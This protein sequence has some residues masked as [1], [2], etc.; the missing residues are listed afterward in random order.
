MRDHIHQVTSHPGGLILTSRAIML[1]LCARSVGAN[2]PHDIR[3]HLNLPHILHFCET[4]LHFLSP[5]G[6]IG[7][8]TWS[9]SCLIKLSPDPP[10]YAKGRTT[11]PG[12]LFSLFK[13]R[14][15]QLSFRMVQGSH[16]KGWVIFTNGKEAEKTNTGRM[17]DP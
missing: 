10:A 16:L 4:F 2:I 9:I 3:T 5:T 8:H 14:Q 17:T 7:S 11:S 12:F 6:G 13:E 1:S 15:Q